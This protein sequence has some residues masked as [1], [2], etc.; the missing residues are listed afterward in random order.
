MLEKPAT[1]YHASLVS[2]NRI[3]FQME[4]ERFPDGNQF[5]VAL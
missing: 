5:D 1:L 3:G 4:I 2:F